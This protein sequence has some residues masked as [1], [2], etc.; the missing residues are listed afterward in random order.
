VPELIELD[1]TR[2]VASPPALDALGSGIDMR[3]SPDEALCFAEV[4]D[5]RADLPVSAIVVPEVGMSGAWFD[6][7]TMRARLA[8]LCEWQ[9]PAR[10]ALGQGMI[11]GIPAKVWLPEGTTEVLLLVATA[12]VHEMEDRLA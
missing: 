8:S 2:I 12:L 6:E 4:D 11:A 10:P 5:L 1:L 7:H 9:L 3:L